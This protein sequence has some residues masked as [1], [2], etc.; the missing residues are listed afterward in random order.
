MDPRSDIPEDH[1]PTLDVEVDRSGAGVGRSGPGLILRVQRWT[2]RRVGRGRQQ[3]VIT[4]LPYAD[5][6]TGSTE[7]FIA[8]VLFTLSGQL[9]ALGFMGYLGQ[10][11]ASRL[12]VAAFA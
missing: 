2:G 3:L 10:R 9:N 11:L 12:S 1:V 7:K 4:S 5:T 6:T 8:A